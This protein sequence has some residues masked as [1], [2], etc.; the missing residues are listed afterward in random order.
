MSPEPATSPYERYQAELHLIAE[1]LKAVRLQLD[2]IKAT[3]SR[4]V[5][6]AGAHPVEPDPDVDLFPVF[7]QAGREIEWHAPGQLAGYPLIATC[8]CGRQIMLTGADAP[9]G[10]SD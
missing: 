2:E 10:H 4:P 7:D 3:L 9:W 5:S 6:H 8:R 1:L